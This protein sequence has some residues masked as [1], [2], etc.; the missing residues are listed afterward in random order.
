[1]TKPEIKRLPQQA[2]DVTGL[3]IIDKRLECHVPDGD[4][5]ALASGMKTYRY[6][7]GSYGVED[8]SRDWLVRYYPNQKIG[9]YSKINGNY[10]LVSEETLEGSRC[11]YDNGQIKEER[12]SDGTRYEYFESG[13]LMK[14]ISSDGSAKEYYQSGKLRSEISSNGSFRSYYENGHI[15]HESLR[16]DHCRK[17]KISGWYENGQLEYEKDFLTDTSVQWDEKSHL[18]SHSTNGIDDT[19]EYLKKLAIKKVAERQVA[20][21]EKLRKDAQKKGEKPERIVVKKL[22]PIQKALEIKKAKKEILK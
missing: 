21:S 10:Q 13:N 6:P 20:K 14:E 11:Y 18:I 7:D 9:F 3:N 19:K 12:F 15:S 17:I 2:D 4:I 16:D 8:D 5:S 1:M 22:A